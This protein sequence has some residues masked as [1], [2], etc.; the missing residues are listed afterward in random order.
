[1][2][3]ALVALVSLTL[4]FQALNLNFILS[5]LEMLCLI[6]TVPLLLLFHI[7]AVVKLVYAC[8]I[9]SV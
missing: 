8:L 7:V 4:I 2:S 6:I 9:N 1:M 5:S 3:E